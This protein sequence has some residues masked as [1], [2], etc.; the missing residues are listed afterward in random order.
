[1]PHYI[2]PFRASDDEDLLPTFQRYPHE[3][4]Q[5]LGPLPEDLD[6]CD[7]SRFERCNRFLDLMLQQQQMRKR[8]EYTMNRREVA[9]RC[10]QHTRRHF[11]RNMAQ[12]HSYKKAA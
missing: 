1:M 9:D 12:Q 8:G 10:A 7:C 4:L 6:A 5:D 3:V 2:H 11:H